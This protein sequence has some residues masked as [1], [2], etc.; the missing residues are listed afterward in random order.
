MDPVRC[1]RPRVPDSDDRR[2][3]R[4]RAWILV[5]VWTTVV[6]ILSGD[7]FSAG[8]TRGWLEELALRVFA[9]LDD[10]TLDLAH[11]LARRA[12]HVLEYAVLALLAGG[13]F[14][15]SGVDRVGRAALFAVLL[16]GAV[17][18]L[19]ESLQA[20]RPQR[21][22]SASHVALDLAGA[23]LGAALFALAARRRSRPE[24]GRV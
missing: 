3:A 8:T 15:A 6:L 22:G 24:R 12:A 5:G 16:A 17:A 1:D 14:V 9:G 7:E 23:S 18:S 13:A 20:L 2:H 10:A 21:S 11:R 19:D 4:T